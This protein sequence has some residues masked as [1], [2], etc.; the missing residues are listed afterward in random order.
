MLGNTEGISLFLYCLYLSSMRWFGSFRKCL[1]KLFFFLIDLIK[2]LVSQGLPI[3]VVQWYQTSHLSSKYY[4]LIDIRIKELI[5][6]SWCSYAN[7]WGGILKS[8]PNGAIPPHSLAYELNVLFSMSRSLREEG[9]MQRSEGVFWNRSK[10]SLT[11]G[12]GLKILGSVDSNDTSC[13]LK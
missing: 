2:P 4:C 6:I 1:Y 7:K 12:F 5:K 9:N 8:L 3:T 10:C 11:F 13:I